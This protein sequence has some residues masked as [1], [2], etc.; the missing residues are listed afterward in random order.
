MIGSR[1][2]HRVDI[3]LFKQFAPVGVLL[4]ARKAVTGLPQ[5]TQIQGKELS[6]NNYNDANAALEL[7]AEFSGA[8]LSISSLLRSTVKK[9]QKPNTSGCAGTDKA[10]EILWRIAA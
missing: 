2:R 4:R 10:N 8:K 1:H 7:V 9:G 6:Y 5:A 3:I